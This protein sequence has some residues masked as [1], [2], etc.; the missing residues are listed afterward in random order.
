MADKS[1]D[2]LELHVLL[3]ETL[4]SLEENCIKFLLKAEQNKL[5]RQLF[6]KKGSF[7]HFVYRLWK[8]FHFLASTHEKSWK[9]GI[10]ASHNTSSVLL[11]TR[12]WKSRP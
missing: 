1:R 2:R 7:S 6:E 9:L 10:F 3:E 4:R 5:I 8:E 11:M 12:L